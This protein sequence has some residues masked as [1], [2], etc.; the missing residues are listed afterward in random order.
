MPTDIKPPKPCS[1]SPPNPIS[2][3]PISI[4][5]TPT[6]FNPSPPPPEPSLVS[7][8]HPNL[9]ARVHMTK[10]IDKGRRGSIE[11]QKGEIEPWGKNYNKK[12][13]FRKKKCMKRCMKNTC[14]TPRMALFEEHFSEQ[15]K[16]L[17]KQI[18]SSQTLIGQ[19]VECKTP[20]RSKIKNIISEKDKPYL[21]LQA[22]TKSNSQSDLIC[23]KGP[24]H[25]KI[26]K[27]LNPEVKSFL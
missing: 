20:N 21:H 23:F 22:S 6:P 7:I 2:P 14:K 24:I 12:V 9:T 16:I 19:R 26:L 25:P 4:H 11:V 8:P 15:E 10:L 13:R 5:L 1:K 18:S 27:M 17:F 3:T